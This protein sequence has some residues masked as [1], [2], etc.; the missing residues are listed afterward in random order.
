MRIVEDADEKLAALRL[1]GKRYNPNDEQALDAEIKSGFNRVAV[2][3]F[4]IER[5]TGKEA[6]E[7]VAQRRV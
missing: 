5:L 1:L 7:Q 3:E 2:I 6:K 4:A